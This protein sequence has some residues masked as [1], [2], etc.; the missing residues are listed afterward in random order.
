MLIRRLE[1]E[2]MDTESEALDYDA[3]DHREVNRRFCDELWSLKHSDEATARTLQVLDVGTGTA[4]IPLELVQRSP[5]L[6]I[7]GIDLAQ[8]MLTV[9]QQNISRAA[10]EKQVQLACVDAKTLPD[11]DGRWDWVISNS[12]LHHIPEPL[13]VLREMIRVL[14][15]GGLLFVRDLLRPNDEQ[16]L[17]YLVETYAA[18]ANAHQRQMFDDSL[19]AAL[20]IAEVRELLAACG[21]D[22]NT[23]QQT[24]DRHWTISGRKPQTKA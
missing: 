21:W 11:A 17:R 8:H 9:G 1:T 23:V 18:G 6:Q 13:S 12:I 3:M 5:Y 14:A 4:Q 22:R 19:H 10:C 2:V 24:S 15:P 7:L 16:T 20:T